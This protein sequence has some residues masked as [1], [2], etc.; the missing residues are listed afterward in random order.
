MSIPVFPKLTPADCAAVV[1]WVNA[2]L[3]PLKD[4]LAELERPEVLE[5]LDKIGA[6]RLS[7]AVKKYA[8]AAVVSVAGSNADQTFKARPTYRDVDVLF[9]IDD[10]R[11]TPREAS[12]LC[13]VL[14]R[15]LTSEVLA[16][17]DACTIEGAAMTIGE[18]SRR[19]DIGKVGTVYKGITWSIPNKCPCC[20][21]Y[22]I[23]GKFVADG[24]GAFV[25][26]DCEARGAG[27]PTR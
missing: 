26:V 25:C 24:A 12:Q 16:Q 5:H 6:P 21:T 27:A 22:R 20:L 11:L 14:G 13:A 23:D 10:P 1:D 9:V 7:D 15:R 19:L 3:R 4:V 8:A 17:R 18:V 2:H